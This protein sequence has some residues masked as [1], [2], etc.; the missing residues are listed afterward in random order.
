MSK[1]NF[2]LILTFLLASNITF[3]GGDS[4]GGVIGGDTTGTTGGTK[5]TKI[6]RGISS[7]D[8][9]NEK[10]SNPIISEFEISLK[11]ALDKCLTKLGS[12]KTH[13]NLENDQDVANEINSKYAEL[14]KNNSRNLDSLNF[15]E[16]AYY[17]N[18]SQNKSLFKAFNSKIKSQQSDSQKKDQT[19]ST[20]AK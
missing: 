1:F 15:P 18:Q 8:E 7:I 17:V 3:G 9:S 16:C 14:E 10:T 2:T 6:S 4:A 5:S 19:Q 11:Q 12:S 20:I 13:L